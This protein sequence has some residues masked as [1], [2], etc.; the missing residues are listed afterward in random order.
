MVAYKLMMKDRVVADFNIVRTSY[1][2]NVNIDKIYLSQLIPL[3]I[4]SGYYTLLSWLESRYILAYKR[5]TMAFFTS[6]GVTNL[7]QFIDITHCASLNDCYWVKPSDSNKKWVNV[8]LYRNA[9]NA[10]ISHYALFGRVLNKNI[11]SSPDFST[12]GNFPKCWRRYKDGIYLLKAGTTGAY[13][14]GYEPYSEVFACQLAHYLGIPVIEQVLTQYR[15]IDVSKSKCICD[16][17]IGIIKLNELT[18]RTGAD[19]K[20]LLDNYNCKL[21]QYMLMLDYLLCNTDRHFGNIWLYFDVNTNQVKDFTEVGDNNLSCMPYYVTDEDLLYYINDIRAKDGRTWVELL[22]LLDSKVIRGIKQ[23]VQGFRL[24]PLG[25]TK[26]D[27]R[28][29][30]LNTML[31]YQISKL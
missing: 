3:G 12:D 16:E 19:F 1:T 31:A 7:E 23:S 25:N 30:V 5:E 8:S 4:Q 9:F 15:G 27:S 17:N 20:W 2:L 24:K 21:I 28:L 11:G 13:N 29:G 10:N 6:I 14:A 26:A 22:S 18:N